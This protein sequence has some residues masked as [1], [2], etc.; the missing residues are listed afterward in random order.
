MDV[1][2]SVSGITDSGVHE[3]MMSLVR[4]KAIEGAYQKEGLKVQIEARD[5]EREIEMHGKQGLVKQT[6]EQPCQALL[7]EMSISELRE[8][9]RI[10]QANEAKELEEKR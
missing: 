10:G 1:Y 7:E 9:L 4:T 5:Q 2:N 8:R 6:M 3:H